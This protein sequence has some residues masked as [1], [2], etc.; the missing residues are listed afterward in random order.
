MKK[1]IFVRHAKSSWKNADLSDM[2]R[3]LNTR[4]EG[5]APK[6]GDFLKKQG[7]KADL[8]I[9]SPANR[10]FT[11]AK[12]IAEKLNYPQAEILQNQNL[13]VFTYHIASIIEIIKTIDNKNENVLLFGH[14]PT[15][16]ALA[17][18]FS[19]RFTTELPTCAA[20]C[21]QFDVENWYDISKENAKYV[22]HAF[23]KML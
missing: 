4:G 1:I 19:N 23:P 14:N 22:F 13:Y 20:V 5:D 17:Y 3:P 16:S 10:A 12:I 7:I 6:I 18:Y 11:T 15:F 8:I 9:S 21:F 2:E